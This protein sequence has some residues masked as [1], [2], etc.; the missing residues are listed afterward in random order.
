MAKI[1]RSLGWSWRRVAHLSTLSWLFPGGAAVVT[2]IAAY[3][4]ELPIA[5]RIVLTLAAFAAALLAVLV[6]QELRKRRQ[7]TLYVECL[8]TRSGETLDGGS[9]DLR[10]ERIRAGEDAPLVTYI[11]NQSKHFISLWVEGAEGAVV[12]DKSRELK[13]QTESFPGMAYLWP[14]ERYGKN[15]PA[16]AG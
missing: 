5:A 11:V 7:R 14:N 8:D 15:D 2:G 6:F 4:Q 10:V 3:L 1:V 16:T 9:L 12:G 13:T